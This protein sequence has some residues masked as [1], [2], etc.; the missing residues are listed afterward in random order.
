MNLDSMIK[1]FAEGLSS[2]I[3][4][5]VHSAENTL[6][7]NVCPIYCESPDRLLSHIGSGVLMQIGESK[8]I[9]TAAHVLDHRSEGTLC[10]P[11]DAELV[12]INGVFR[13]TDIPDGGSREDDK[14][15]VGFCRLDEQTVNSIASHSFLSVTEIVA[16]EKPVFGRLYSFVGFPNTRNEVRYNIRP[17]PFSFL[18]TPL[19]TDLYKHYILDSNIHIAVKYDK[20]RTVG[21][22]H[23]P[24]SFPDPH[25]LSGG[26]L[27][28]W[29]ILDRFKVGNPEVSPKLVGITTGCTKDKKAWFATKIGIALECVRAT[30]KDLDQSIP[31]IGTLRVNVTI[32]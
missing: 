6:V 22:N 28:G 9:L 11:G 18:N 2:R 27:W 19:T 16:D 15:D 8:F 3:I 1:S 29:E 31:R 26:G 23:K 32:R 7:K 21:P 24:I 12:P 17:A 10:M 30:C 5:K 13:S 20:K 25:G 4:E 14:V